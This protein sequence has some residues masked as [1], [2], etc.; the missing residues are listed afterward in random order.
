MEGKWHLNGK[1]LS[2]SDFGDPNRK[3]GFQDI[4]YQYNRGHWKYF[5]E[6]ATNLTAYEWDA[7][8]KFTSNGRNEEDFYATDF[9]F[10]KAIDFM[11]KKSQNG[12][13]FAVM[14]SIADPRKYFND[15]CAQYQYYQAPNDLFW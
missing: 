13:K 7:R 12:K 1:S 9:L 15:F 14:L 11:D 6:T 3:F 5:E 8:Q 4:D 10:Q 2:T